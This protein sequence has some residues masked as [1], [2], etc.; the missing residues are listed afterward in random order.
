[1]VEEKLTLDGDCSAPAQGGP[2]IHC[3]SAAHPT[4]PDSFLQFSN[5][6][7][8]SP[9]EP[10]ATVDMVEA[11]FSLMDFLRD[12]YNVTR[13]VLHAPVVD[14]TI[15]ESGFFGSGV[16]SN[17]LFAANPVQSHEELVCFVL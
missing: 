7:V 13:L 3:Y 2:V 10:A 16:G 6:L 9:E 5:V 15:D 1:M 11:E 12:N 17:V 8:G 4:V 14:F